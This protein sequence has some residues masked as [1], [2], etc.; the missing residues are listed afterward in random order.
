M[1][2]LIDLEGKG[3]ELYQMLHQLFQT[4]MA[5]SIFTET[6]FQV[7]D[8]VTNNIAQKETVSNMVRAFHQKYFDPRMVADLLSALNSDQTFKFPD[9]GIYPTGEFILRLPEPVKETLSN[10]IKEIAIYVWFKLL[11]QV[12]LDESKR[13]TYAGLLPGQNN[14]NLILWE[15]HMNQ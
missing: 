3:S 6:F 15:F 7:G 4:Q 12:S 9:F 14:N 2:V 11:E 1:Y 8:L 5:N 10:Q 13:F